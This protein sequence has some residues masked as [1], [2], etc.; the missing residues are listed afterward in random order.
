[1]FSAIRNIALLATV[2]SAILVAP[3]YAAE[4]AGQYIDDAT[5]GTK[6][7]VALVENETVSA[8]DINVEVYKGVVQLSGFVD[9]E[10]EKAAALAVA[11]K[12]E[13]A[14]KVLDAIVVLPGSRSMG[15]AVDDTTIHAKLKA[16]LANVQGI[17][18]AVAIN[19]KVRHRQVLLAGFVDSD[20][21]KSGAGKA[22][23]GIAGVKKVHNLIAVQP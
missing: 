5:V 10:A 4:T 14:K 22:A 6:T 3:A 20:S 8:A 2:G 17:S 19:T 7:K 9:S 13:G 23:E 11:G 1:M 21:V 16:E 12:V 18:N 15:E